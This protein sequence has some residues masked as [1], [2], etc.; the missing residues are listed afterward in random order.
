MQYSPR[1]IG[2]WG[3]FNGCHRTLL[4]WRRLFV[5]DYTCVFQS[6][7]SV[8]VAV[9]EGRQLVKHIYVCFRSLVHSIS[10][11]GACVRGKHATWLFLCEALSFPAPRFPYI[12]ACTYPQNIHKLAHS[13]IPRTETRMDTQYS[14]KYTACQ[15]C[16]YMQGRTHNNTHTN[17]VPVGW[18]PPFAPLASLPLAPLASFPFAPFASLGGI[19]L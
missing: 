12:L 2:G 17:T 10:C 13:H 3:Y 18:T 19:L 9:G 6:I 7:A 11:L 16:M 8:Y 4:G 14:V 5:C 1:V 15:P